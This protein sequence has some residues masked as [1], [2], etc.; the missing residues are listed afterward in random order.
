MQGIPLFFFFLYCLTTVVYITHVS[1]QKYVSTETMIVLRLAAP[2]SSTIFDA[3]VSW[4][5]SPLMTPVWIRHRRDLSHAR[6]KERDTIR[7]GKVAARFRTQDG[8]GGYAVYPHDLGSQVPELAPKMKSPIPSLSPSSECD[9]C[10]N[11]CCLSSGCDDAVLMNNQSPLFAF[12]RRARSRCPIGRFSAGGVARLSH[13][14]PVPQS[15]SD[16]VLA[17]GA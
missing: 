1:H 5:R 15:Y 16:C 3:F 7:V 13:R 6:E 14:F 9:R 8:R 17:L 10:V 11:C 12:A 2:A 4:L